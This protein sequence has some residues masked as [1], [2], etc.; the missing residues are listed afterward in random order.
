MVSA[1]AMYWLTL[2]I[3]SVSFIASRN[4]GCR[5]VVLAHRAQG[6]AAMARN[7]YRSHLNTDVGNMADYARMQAEAARMQV[8]QARMEADFTRGNMQKVL[9]MKRVWGPEQAR[10][11]KES[12]RESGVTGSGLVCPRGRVRVSIPEIPAITD[13]SNADV[14]DEDPI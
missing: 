4:P 12:L 8:E 1:K 5:L 7:P 6:Y 13:L 10:Q 9:V 11:L 14:S 2:G 3:L